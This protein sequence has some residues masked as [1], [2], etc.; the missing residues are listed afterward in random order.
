MKHNQ[1]TIRQSIS[2]LDPVSQFTTH[3][4]RSLGNYIIPNQKNNIPSVS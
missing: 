4:Y 1:V 3:G 2:Y